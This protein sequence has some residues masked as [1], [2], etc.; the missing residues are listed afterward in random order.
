M[1]PVHPQLLSDWKPH[2]LLTLGIGLNLFLGGANKDMAL[3]PY[4]ADKLRPFVAA[5]AA[6]YP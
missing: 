1:I 4:F 6:Q 3:S 2:T 5:W